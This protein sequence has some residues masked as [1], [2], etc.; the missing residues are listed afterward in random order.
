MDHGCYPVTNSFGVLLRAIPRIVWRTTD[1]EGHHGLL[2]GLGSVVCRT[3]NPVT[4]VILTTTFGGLH[5]LML[6]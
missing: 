3:T 4:P 2:L 1:H 6:E 5:G